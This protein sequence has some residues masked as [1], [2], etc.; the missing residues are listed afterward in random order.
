MDPDK[1]DRIEEERTANTKE[2]HLDQVFSKGLSGVKIF[3]LILRKIYKPLLFLLLVAG[4]F[5][6]GYS[7]K[8]CPICDECK[9][10]E[11]CI[12]C[13]ELDCEE[14]PAKI[15]KVNVVKYACNNGLVVDDMDD[16]DPLNH[17]KI[18]T[19]YKETNNG[20]TLAIDNIEYESTDTFHKITQIDYTILNIGEHEIK[21][22]VLV[23]LYDVNSEKINQ[24]LVHEVFDDNEYVESQA[25][26]IKKKKTNIGFKAEDIIVRLVLKDT[27]PDPDKE[28]VRV[29]Q[30]VSI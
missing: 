16:C 25:W 2:I 1:R 5:F 11:V 23:N 22:I 19:P 29:S 15:E 7:M 26:A 3:F 8:E 18:T 13:P 9:E 20:V 17:V 10:C 12:T 21:P 4:I 24:G 27:L 30:P 6:A 28:L 14:C